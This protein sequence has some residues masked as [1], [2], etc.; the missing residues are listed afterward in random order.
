MKREDF[1]RFKDLMRGAWLAITNGKDEPTTGLLD[2]FWTSFRNLSIEDFEA[3]IGSHLR[4][5]KRG[6]FVP[7]P[8]DIVAAIEE[9]RR[10]DGRPSADEAWATALHALD[11]ANTVV[12]TRETADAWWLCLQVTQRDRV[13]GRKAFIAAYERNVEQA[14][15]ANDPVQW[16]TTIGTDADRRA[17]AIEQAAHRNLISCSHA[18]ALIANVAGSHASASEAGGSLRIE[19]K[20]R[21][22]EGAA[23]DALAA[24]AR[25]ELAERRKQR[26]AEEAAAAAKR[27]QPQVDVAALGRLQAERS[28]K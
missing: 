15:A 14:R 25:A 16:E 26:E 6:Q 13:G 24:K 28:L 20:D 19:H 2:I 12:W 11:E 8:A 3:A 23:F 1:D 7:K 17:L 4:N 18:V 21:K 27:A 9:Q 22:A 5:P 10:H